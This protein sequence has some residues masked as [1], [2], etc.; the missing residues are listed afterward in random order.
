MLAETFRYLL[1]FAIVATTANVVSAAPTAD[2]FLTSR[3]AVRVFLLLYLI[4]PQ[5][6]IF[7]EG[8]LSCRHCL[9]RHYQPTS[10]MCQY[11]RRLQHLQELY[12]RPQFLE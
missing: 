11:P 7:C 12:W 6:Y 10:G 8:I 4:V 9:Q 5:V 2:A 1:A 3:A